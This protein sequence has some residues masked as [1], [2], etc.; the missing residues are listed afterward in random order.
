MKTILI[1]LFSLCWAFGLVL[2]GSPVEGDFTLQVVSCLVGLL[3]FGTSTLVLY[4]LLSKRPEL[5]VVEFIN[6]TPVTVLALDYF[7]AYEL[8]LNTYP[9]V[10]PACVI[11]ASEYR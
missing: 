11:K 4:L 7:D 5:F 8:A 10:R 9:F 2:A 6:S 1:G 3:I